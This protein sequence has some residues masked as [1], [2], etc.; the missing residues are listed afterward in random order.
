MEKEF[1]LNIEK[2]LDNWEIY[3]AV[4]EIIANAI[5]EM[6]LTNTKEIEIFK[7]DFGY[8][9]IR[10]YGRGLKYHH[11]TQNE[12]EEKINSNIVIGKFG[13][14]LKDALAVLYKNNIDMFISSKYGKITLKMLGKI[15]FN[16]TI[17]LHAII[18]EPIDKN[19]VGTDFVINVNDDD[20]NKAKE[21]F[22][23]FR[24]E[25]PLDEL[26]QGEIYKKNRSASIFVRGVK[27]AEE[28]NYLFDYNIVKLNKNLSKALNRERSNVGRVAYSS[29]IKQMLLESRSKIVID[30]LMAELQKIPMGTNSDEVNLVDIQ[31]HATKEYNAIHN[32]VIVSASN[33]YNFTN[34]DKEKIIESGREVVI[35]PD[36]AYEKL[37]GDKD[38]T[39]KEIGTFQTVINEYTANFEYKFIE[40]EKLSYNEKLIFNLKDKIMN[41]YPNKFNR[42]I[43]ISETINEIISGDTLGVYDM[44]SNS[45]IIKREVLNDKKK[46]C[47]VLFHELVHANTGYNDNTRNF[48]NEL[49]KI[50]GIL[51]ELVLR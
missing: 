5:D 14:G 37:K 25:K 22:L 15:G 41:I 51:S 42:K 33:A 19:M 39:G 9:H 26:Q 34:D 43:L 11:L 44:S 47:N 10:D 20:I 21:L 46:F 49:G 36:I 3:H 6:K 32:I 2:I 7:D 17:T 40:Y 31:A 28:P 45:I 18:Q 8:W 48:E 4:R 13:V 50:I 38:Y 1:D 35:V 29:I 16:D 23:Y 27:V 30:T 24:N 12:N